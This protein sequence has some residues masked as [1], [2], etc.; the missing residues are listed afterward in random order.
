[1]VA[2]LLRHIQS[3]HPSATIFPCTAATF[4]LILSMFDSPAIINGELCASLNSCFC[5]QGRAFYFI[6]HPFLQYTIRFTGMV[7]ILGIVVRDISIDGTSPDQQIVDAFTTSFLQNFW[8][9]N[10]PKIFNNEVTLVDVSI[11]DKRFP[12]SMFIDDL[13]GFETSIDY[14]LMRAIIFFSTFILTALTYACIFFCVIEGVRG[15]R[16]SSH[17]IFFINR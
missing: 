12:L 7:D 4:S 2:L 16:G 1:M 8:W 6:D 14:F 3:L 10:F 9:N 17:F 5:K 11:S 15:G 13:T